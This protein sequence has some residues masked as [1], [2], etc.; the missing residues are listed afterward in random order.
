V[1]I[2]DQ[3]SDEHA[4]FLLVTAQQMTAQHTTLH[5]LW[6]VL[7]AE[8]VTLSHEPFLCPLR[9][10]AH[11]HVQPQIILQWSKVEQY[12]NLLRHVTC[13]QFACDSRE[14]RILLSHRGACVWTCPQLLCELEQPEGEPVTFWSQSD[15]QTTTLQ[16]HLVMHSGP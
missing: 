12:L 1:Y 6:Q 16:C 11:G 10:A 7:H 2:L 8:F 3:Y 14:W 15:T 4:V 13:S 9:S 5:G